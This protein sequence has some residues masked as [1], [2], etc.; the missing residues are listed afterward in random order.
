ME[1]FEEF[2]QKGVKEKNMYTVNLDTPRIIIVASVAIGVIIISF[3]LGMNLYKAH[4]KPGDSLAQRDSLLDLPTDSISPGRIPP[5]DDSMMNAQSEIDRLIMPGAGER[6]KTPAA[7]GNE[8]AAMEKNS[9][10]HDVLTSEAIKEIIPPAPDLKEHAV[11]AEK[12]KP[13]KKQTVKKGDKSR[14]Q[15]TVEVVSDTKKETSHAL[16]GEYSVQVAAFDKKSKAA[17]EIESLK[18]MKYD[19]F[20]DRTQVNGKSYFRVRIGPIATKARALDI[21]NEIQEDSR[22]TESFMI[23]E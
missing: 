14:R 4:E 17:T 19:A 16:R 7:R 22:Y 5:P 23:R 8:F 10:S 20:M 9:L 6:D 3:L 1:H 13:S 12:I 18:K 15:K 21:L 11:P 2:H